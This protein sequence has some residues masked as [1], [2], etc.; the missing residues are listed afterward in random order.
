MSDEELEKIR[1]QRLKEMAEKQQ[2]QG[3]TEAEKEQAAA[4]EAQKKAAL[5]RILTPEA[6]QRLSNLRTV[7]PQF[8]ESIEQQLI[9]LHSQGRVRGKIDD[10]RLKAM[11]KKAQSG[12][13]D[14]S[15]RRK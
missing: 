13:R 7:K 1:E 3:S 9:L 6:R 15:I 11:L 12:R 8:A 10:D 4:A 5:R 14:I 2:Q